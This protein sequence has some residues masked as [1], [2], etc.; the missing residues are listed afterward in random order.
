LALL[1]DAQGNRA[2]AEALLSRAL[3][4]CEKAYGSEHPGVVPNL[5]FLATLLRRTRRPAEAQKVEARARAIRA[6]HSPKLPTDAGGA[7]FLWSS[8][9]E[10]ISKCA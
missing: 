10:P 1:Y 5:E 7:K 8:A 3:G 4:I 6:K 2:Q 9:V